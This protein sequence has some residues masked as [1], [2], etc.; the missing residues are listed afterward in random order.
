MDFDASGTQL[1]IIDAKYR[2]DPEACCHAVFQHWVKGN[3]VRPCSWRK[4]IELIEDVDQGELAHKI[5]AALSS[6]HKPLTGWSTSTCRHH[7]CKALWCLLRRI[8]AWDMQ[9][10]S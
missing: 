5:E 9:F 4:L 2:G 7:H 1:D 3:G 6:L 8:K 10:L